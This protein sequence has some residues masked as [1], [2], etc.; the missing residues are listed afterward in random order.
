MEATPDV[1]PYFRFM[2][3]LQIGHSDSVS[4]NDT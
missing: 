2:F 3:N 4:Y 1:L